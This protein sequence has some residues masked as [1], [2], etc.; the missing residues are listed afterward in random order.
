MLG[1]RRLLGF[2]LLHGPLLRL[3]VF[4]LRRLRLRLLA[5]VELRELTADRAQ[6]LV[7]VPD[8]RTARRRELERQR[9]L[10]IATCRLTER[11]LPRCIEQ[12]LLDGPRAKIALGE[13]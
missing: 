13:L 5:L 3:L 9:E 1:P 8:L 4:L 2:D 12:A 7:L 6:R 11:G 10:G